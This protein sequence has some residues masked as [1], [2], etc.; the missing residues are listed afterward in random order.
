VANIP[1]ADNLDRA[2]SLFCPISD[3]ALKISQ[4]QLQIS[5]E[6]KG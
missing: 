2:N 5:G 3:S 4:H 6:K 1:V